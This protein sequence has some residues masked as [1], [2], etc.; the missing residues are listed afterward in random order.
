ML[1]G[2]RVKQGTYA[3]KS[4]LAAGASLAFGSDWFVAPPSPLIGIHAAT[5]RVTLAPGAGD[6]RGPTAF[7]PHERISVSAHTTKAH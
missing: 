7:T 1:G 2:A 5:H 6:R 4:L 3:F